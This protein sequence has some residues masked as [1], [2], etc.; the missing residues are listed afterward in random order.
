MEIFHLLALGIRPSSCKFQ[1]E[2]GWV[3]R[4]NPSEY[5]LVLEY[6]E[7]DQT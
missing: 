2:F 3:V 7:D 4:V 6:A 1:R 5:V